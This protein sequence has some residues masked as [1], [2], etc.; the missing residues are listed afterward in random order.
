MYLLSSCRAVHFRVYQCQR[1]ALEDLRRANLPAG[2]FAISPLPVL[3]MV[4]V[5]SSISLEGTAHNIELA[6]TTVDR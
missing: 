2:P 6:H 4:P 3:L 5:C 1:R